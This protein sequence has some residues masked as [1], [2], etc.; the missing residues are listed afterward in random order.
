MISI[1]PLMLYHIWG[2]QMT[3][4]VSKYTSKLYMKLTIFLYKYRI[5]STVKFRNNLLS[6]IN[7]L[8]WI[9]LYLREEMRT[10]CLQMFNTDIHF[11]YEFH[12]SLCDI[13]K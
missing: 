1:F 8:T 3:R 12:T 2:S 13:S 4:I 6:E 10:V 9:L 11:P 7:L 5:L